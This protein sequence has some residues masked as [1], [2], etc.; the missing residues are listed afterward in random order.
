MSNPHTNTTATNTSSS[1][2]SG[3]GDKIKGAFQVAHGVGDAI[4]GSTLGAADS[5]MSH[6]EA[7]A[8]NAGIANKGSAEYSEGMNRMRG[9]GGNYP[10]ST[11]TTS[12]T[13]ASTGP[14]STTTAF[15]DPSYT[16]SDYESRTAGPH[17]GFHGAG[18]GAGPGYGHGTGNVGGA[19]AGPDGTTSMGTGV[20]TGAG[21]GGTGTG[22]AVHAM[23][24]TGINPAPQG[25]TQYGDAAF[26]GRAPAEQRDFDAGPRD[27]SRI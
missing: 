14:G 6:N 20:D 2:G 24:G 26:S 21:V 19:G 23:S 11:N 1:A 17:T 12:T 27:P 8:K 16:T 3:I 7:Q 5:A 4:R 25:A 15:A 18:S 10:P 13:T 22:P 9:T